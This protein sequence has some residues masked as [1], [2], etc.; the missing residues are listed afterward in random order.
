MLMMALA[1]VA[2]ADSGWDNYRFNSGEYFDR[3]FNQP[4]ILYYAQDRAAYEATWRMMGRY[5]IRRRNEY[6]G[7]WNLPQ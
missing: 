2:R 1:G 3:F 6:T 4:R 5:G 7:Q